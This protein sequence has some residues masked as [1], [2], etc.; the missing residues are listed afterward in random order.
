MFVK[1][2]AIAFIVASL[3]VLNI[4]QAAPQ[5]F[6]DQQEQR[7]AAKRAAEESQRRSQ[8]EMV[9]LGKKKKTLAKLILPEET[10]SFFVEEIILEGEKSESFAWVQRYLDR[11]K[12]S[13]IG[14][15]GINLLLQQINEAILEKG[16][17]TSKI[18][19][20]EQDISSGK[21]IFTL[22][23]GLVGQIRFAEENTWGTWQ[24]AFPILPGDLLNIRKIE[25]G[26]EQMRRVPSQDIDIDIQPSEIAGQSDLVISV[27][28]SKP[29]RIVISM[30]DS[31]TKDT[32]KSQTS[33]SLGLDNL[34]SVNDILNISYNRDAVRDGEIKG[35][36]ANSFYYSVPFGRQTFS[37]SKSRNSY[38]QTVKTAVWPM[39]YSGISHYYNF[40]VTH[41]LHRNQKG[42]TDL[43]LGIIKKTRRSFIDN[44]EI[45]VQRQSTTAM[46]LGVI[47]KKYIGQSVVDIALRYQAGT[48]LFGA[49]PGVTDKVP[50][51]PTTQYSM[52]LFDFNLNAPFKL[53]NLKG[54]YNLTIRGQHTKYRLY[55]SEFFS[56]GGR[57]TVRGFDGEQS[58]SAE[59]GYIIR[60][61]LSFPIIK[62]QHQLYTALDYGKVS[63]PSTKFLLGKELSGFAIGLRGNI[64]PFQYDVFVGWPIRK[65]DGY[66]TQNQA[67]GFY[68]TAQ[69]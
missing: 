38:H 21:L 55:G 4:V 24:N 3:S 37:F 63:G 44:T 49:R 42:K 61:E 39:K 25:Q 50:N 34:F 45:S 52:Y 30:D 26:L 48:H 10:P 14:M 29:W 33:S 36:R 59:S 65:P 28:R 17:V 41:L 19:I 9:R 31:G 60:Q 8:E 43:E 1:K 18:Y 16:F 15:N 67:F 62:K 40:T 47:H 57:Y 58:L 56:I 22:A 68:V 53:E 2:T 66:K 46:R 11:Y 6:L 35:T 27:K 5:D 12:N 20:T 23:P 69:F 51:S 32:G 7:E 64:K 13:N 54:R